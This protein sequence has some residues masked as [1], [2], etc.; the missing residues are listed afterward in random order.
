MTRPHAIH[1][2]GEDWSSG[3]VA[4]PARTSW[5]EELAGLGGVSPLLHFVDAPTTRIEL[6][7]THPGGV[8]QFITGKSTLLSQLIR[9]D[10]ALRGARIAA[11]RI[12]AKG[13]EL[14]TTRGLDAIRLGIGVVRWRHAGED[15]CAPLLLR[16]LAIRR[17]GRDFELKLR[18][19]AFLNPALAAALESQFGISLDAQAFVALSQGDGA[20]KPNAVIDQLRALTGHLLDFEVQPRL[21]V[22]SFAEV[23]PAL[24]R[25]RQGPRA[26]RARRPGR[27]LDG[28]MGARGGLLAGRAD[29]SRPPRAVHRHPAARRRLRAGAHRRA[30]RR[31]Q[32]ARREAR[33][34]A[35]AAPRRS[36]TRSAASSGRTSACSWSA[37]V[38]R[39]SAASPSDSA[40]SACRGSPSRRARLR[41]DVVRGIARNERVDAAPAR[42]GRRGAG[43]AAPRAARLPRG[44]VAP[45]L[46]ALGLGLRLRDRAVPPGAAAASAGHHRPTRPGRPSSSS[47]A[48]A[49][50]S[51]R[52]W[53]RPRSSASSATDPATR[54][55][56][57]P[58]S[59]AATTP[60]RAHELA[61]RLHTEELPRL[62][63]RAQELIGSTRMRP[64]VSIAELGVY[65]HLLTELRDTLD[66]FQPAVFDRS[67]SELIVAT[68]PR[69]DA[70][71]MSSV[72]RRRLSK[73]AQGVRASRD[74]RRRPARGAHPHPAAA[75]PLA[76]LRRSPASRP[77]CRSASP[78]CRSRGSR[79]SQDLAALDGPLGRNTRE[80]Q[81]GAPCRSRCSGSCWTASPPTPTCCTTCRSA[82]SS[83]PGCATSSST[84]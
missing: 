26:S 57:A 32:L 76:A 30:D 22:S 70:P 50:R 83:S 66:K 19:Q 82:A 12:A 71:E 23:A 48:T 7:T 39:R 78:T 59:P 61:K 37:P 65:L 80:T 79:S 42:R 52:R 75:H 1:V 28:E 40:T 49:P 72:N 68:A 6:S 14:T 81:L 31:R 13:L 73:L 27:Q 18:G 67:L 38:A 77:R 84:P 62:L 43:P 45:R 33:C 63:V 17:H 3:N 41:R 4:D 34:P 10:I 53:S 8:A 47:P 44:A 20:F 21:V 2:G 9:D 55:G 16:P 56:T 25:R 60:R 51:P 29:R 5:R 11:D 64:F 35:P 15:F 36:S 46:G 24:A 69:R 74:A 54:P 58:R